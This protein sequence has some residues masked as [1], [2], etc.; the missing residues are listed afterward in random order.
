MY[1]SWKYWSLAKVRTTFKLIYRF[2]QN[3]RVMSTKVITTTKVVFIKSYHWL[4]SSPVSFPLKAAWGSQVPRQGKGLTIPR[5]IW[6]GQ[7]EMAHRNPCIVTEELR[8]PLGRFL[9]RYSGDQVQVNAS[10]TNETDHS[11][12]IQ[13]GPKPHGLILAILNS[14]QHWFVQQMGSQ[15][16]LVSMENHLRIFLL[17]KHWIKHTWKH[18]NKTQCPLIQMKKLSVPF[19]LLTAQCSYFLLFW[20]WMLLSQCG[21]VEFLEH[22]VMM[23]RHLYQ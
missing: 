6:A 14:A 20:G 15:I 5:R 22:F 10:C 21:S 11:V 8:Q 23:Y 9:V 1:Q 19:C 17:W 13:K 4:T 12:T 7:G 2:S 16:P 18:T 3:F